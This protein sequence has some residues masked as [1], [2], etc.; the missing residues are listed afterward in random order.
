VKCLQTARSPQ[1]AKAVGGSSALATSV[2]FFW[3][4]TAFD[5]V[6]GNVVD[7][8]FDAL[9]QLDHWL[10]G[11]VTGGFAAWID[12]PAA[13]VVDDFVLAPSSFFY[14]LRGREGTFLGRVLT[15]SPSA[16]VPEPSTMLLLS[17]GLV[18]LIRRVRR[19]AACRKLELLPIAPSL[20]P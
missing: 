17:S 7:L 18:A 6:I 20:A 12:R 10:L 19:P 8:R 14:A 9:G 2:S 5:I 1:L 16:P 3:G 4:T 15:H 13:A 11:G